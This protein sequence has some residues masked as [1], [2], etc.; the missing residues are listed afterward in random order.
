MSAVAGNVA[1]GLALVQLFIADGEV[2][3]VDVRVDRPAAAARRLLLGKTPAEAL[4]LVPL[5][6]AV[7]GAAQSA[8]A[9]TACEQAMG[10]ALDPAR[11]SVRN[12][13]AAA[14]ALLA[15]GRFFALDWPQVAGEA[16]Q[17]EAFVR[18]RK[19]LTPIAAILD[20]A[21]AA[22][23]PGAEAARVDAAALRAAAMNAAE[24]MRELTQTARTPAND[25]PLSVIPAKAGI[26]LFRNVADEV[27]L[28]LRGGDDKKVAAWFAERLAADAGFAERPDI[29]GVPAL[30]LPGNLPGEAPPMLSAEALLASRTAAAL[31]TAEMLAS[32]NADDMPP[33][34]AAHE[35]CGLA[36]TARG[37]LAHWVR[38]ERGR[39]ADWRA[40]APT[41][42][43]FHPQGALAQ[44][45]TGLPVG[46]QLKAAAERLVCALDPCVPWRVEITQQEGSASHA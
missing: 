32:D 31:R 24:A 16:P 9:A 46:P 23:I 35:G 44:A 2:K 13:L 15:H 30:N 27:D 37:L 7:C 12:R 26:H 29:D 36:R 3:Q 8:A 40:V 6:F 4:K 18:L 45:L 19:A 41:E 5:L 28:R 10:L 20:P 25:F 17:V 34:V 21:R 39:I 11:L 42:W 38:L 1:T 22:F 33:P 43:N 14:E